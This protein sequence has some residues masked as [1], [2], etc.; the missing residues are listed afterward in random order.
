MEKSNHRQ[1]LLRAD[2]KRPRHRHAADKRDELAP[3]CMTG[4]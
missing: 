4:K 3:P 1:L 2:S